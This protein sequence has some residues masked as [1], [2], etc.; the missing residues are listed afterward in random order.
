MKQLRFSS[1]SLAVAGLVG[2]QA[3]AQVSLSGALSDTTTGPLLA[4]TVYHAT[5]PLSV[6]SGQVLT[7]QDGVVVKFPAAGSMTVAGTLAVVGTSPNPVIFTSILDDAAGGDTNADGAATLPAAGDWAGLTFEKDSDA[8]VVDWGEVRYAGA[9]GAAGV[10]LVKADIALTNST[11]R[12]CQS[13]GVSLSEN[14]Y[15]LVSGCTISG[16]LTAVDDVHINAIDGFSNN[17]ATGNGGNYQR[18][19]AGSMIGLSTIGPDQV[20]GGAL[21]MATTLTIP[22]VLTLTLEAGT[23]VKFA[24]GTGI[25]VIGFLDTNG[26]PEQPV[27]FTSFP[28]DSIGGDTNA[29]GTSVGNPGT[30]WASPSARAP[31]AASCST[32]RCA[33]PV[34][35][36]F[37]PSV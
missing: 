32:A 12:D 6:A 3:L 9:S 24:P 18:V 28:D 23:A 17:T 34:R 1:V 8:S 37:P 7:V 2:G 30:G 35:R 25:D 5:G 4:G 14:S 33:T 36:D 27:V 21:V 29:D 26:T 13:D 31:T 10:T 22:S 16:T 20:L 19:T 11:I 15:P